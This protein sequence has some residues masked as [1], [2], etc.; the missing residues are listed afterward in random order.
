[1]TKILFVCSGNVGRSQMAEAFYNHYTKSKNA[2]SAGISRSTPRLYP[3]LPLEIFQVMKEEGIDVSEQMAKT[4]TKGMVD[5]ADRI[6]VMCEREICPDFL[7]NSRK[8]AFWQ[9][10][11]PHKMGMGD[12]R[13][14]RDEVKSKVISIIQK[15]Q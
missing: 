14:V 13:K 1:M 7:L 5:N 10:E 3:N 11:D 8:T 2:S 6:F 15:D 4:L 12:I 9:I